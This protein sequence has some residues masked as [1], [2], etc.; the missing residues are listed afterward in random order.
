MAPKNI[1]APHLQ[2][3]LELSST[4]PATKPASRAKDIE[5][6]MKEV[7]RAFGATSVCLLSDLPRVR[8]RS[9][10]LLALDVATGI[11]GW[12]NGRVIEVYGPDSSGKTTLALSAVASAQRDGSYGVFVDADQ[13]LDPSY[14]AILGVDPDRLLVIS[15]STCEQAFES[16]DMLLRSGAVSIAVIDSLPALVGRAEIEAEMG[17]DNE[18]L[19]S[20]LVGQALRKLLGVLAM[21]GS[22]LIFIN[23][24]RRLQNVVFGNPETTPGGNMLRAQASLRID[25][26][27]VKLLRRDDKLVGKR[28]RMKIAK[29]KV[30]AP[31]RRCE[32]DLLFGIGF[33]RSAQI[34]DMAR[35]AD[36]IELQADGFFF[37]TAW[38]GLDEGSILRRIEV[39]IDLAN[40]IED[41]VR[42]RLVDIA[43][44]LE[45]S[46][47]HAMDFDQREPDPG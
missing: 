24:I 46:T 41:L 45:A 6:T 21:F 3:D 10:G 12:P 26:R 2:V 5:R 34:F 32:C 42:E 38:L 27:S 31:F 13:S 33:S 44:P 16:L 29:N 30:A 25:L 36:I 43:L 39:D 17:D 7:H 14:A 11:G 9:T 15:P 1:T 28:I 35:R 20:R 40:R 4:R 22:N 37:G 23:Q 47:P 19:Q 18:I 8:A